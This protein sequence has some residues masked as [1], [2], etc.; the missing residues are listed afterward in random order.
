[1]TLME[2]LS[3]AQEPVQHTRRFVARNAFQ[4]PPIQQLAIP[5]QQAL[6]HA[7]TF[8]AGPG[9]RQGGHD[10]GGGCGGQGCAPFAIYMRNLGTVTA[11]PS[12]IVLFGGGSMQLPLGQGGVQQAL[13]PDFSNIHKWYNNW[14]VC[15]CAD[16]TLKTDTH[17][18]RVHSG[19]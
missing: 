7:G 19:R 1:M 2:A 15:S 9:G 18:S 8:H 5:T 14:N 11:M 4:V 12:H 13:N 16:S 3:Y 6:F 17:P 10:R